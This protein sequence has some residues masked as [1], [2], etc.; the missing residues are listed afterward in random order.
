MT[1]KMSILNFKGG[2]G[3]TSL[4]TN[5]SHALVLQGASVLLIDC[6]MQGNSSTLL[7]SV[8]EPTLTH[9]LRGQAKLTDAIRQARPGLDLVPADTNLNKAS[10]YI[11]SEGRTSY[12][13]L[14]KAITALTKY[15]YIFF[16][17][18]PNYNAVTESALLASDEMLIPC[19][20]S[21]FAVEGLLKMFDKLEETLVEHS[22]NI[23]GI[24]PFK[25]NRSIAMHN[26]YLNDLRN[27]FGVQ[28]LAPI[29]T[30]TAVGKAQSYHI[31]IF[32][33]DV[34]EK[35]HSK[36][37]DDFKELATTLNGGK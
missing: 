32:E 1:R 5:L 28:V 34:Q 8:Q 29:R 19:E 36:S 6:D 17:H 26:G 9:V 3:K 4:A 18:S 31:S 37:A 30:D 35:T 25:L 33:Y 11:I 24:V 15:D 12:Y 14:R 23:A 10:N 7:E 13:A 22:L 21:P 20:L 27:S 2:V 16:D